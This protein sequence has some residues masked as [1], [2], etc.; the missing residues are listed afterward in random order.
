MKCPIRT[1]RG[2]R[3]TTVARWESRETK[4]NHVGGATL[5]GRKGIGKM[6]GKKEKLRILFSKKHRRSIIIHWRWSTYPS[7]NN[8]PSVD[9]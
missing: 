5:R 1:G 8:K 4:K 2:E 7:D 3:L 6:R 9:V